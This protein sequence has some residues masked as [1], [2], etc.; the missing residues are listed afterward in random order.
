MNTGS[1]VIE[2]KNLKR[3][4]GKL[5]AVNGLNL[6]VRPGRCFGLFG[7]NGAGKTTTIKCLLNL[8]RPTS[9]SV[10]VF[11]LDPRR[12]E[13]AVK[14]RLAY[15]PD[16][17]AFYPWMTVRETLYYLASFRRHWNPEVEADLLRRF[18]LDP[19]QKTSH[20]SK[21]QKTQLALIG[22]ICPETELLLLDEPTSGLDP[23]VRREFIETV[24]GAYQSGDPER[25]TVF[26]STH[27]IAEFEGLIDEFTIIEQGR[28]LFSMEADSARDR[29]RKIRARFAGPPPAMKLPGALDV[30]QSGRE[31][32]LLG[33]GNC[34]QLM[35][36][37]QAHN[38]EELHCESL[39]LEEIFVASK[40]LMEAVP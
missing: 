16:V 12:D 21:G 2:V 4:F 13:V 10:S 28:E 3:R 29:F 31:L 30:R 24:I 5:D 14:S 18:E 8:L 39:S 35:E 20:L 22:A 6:N 17:V 27:L 26:V 36:I 7:R 23:I 34:E 9:G 33:N 32:E 15:V 37:L 19:A 40:I 38:P 11:G 25:R 1:A